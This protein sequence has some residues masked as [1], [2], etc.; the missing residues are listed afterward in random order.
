MLE[1]GHP[2][3]LKGGKRPYHTII[4]A[5]ALRGDELFLSYGV[6]G[7]YMQVGRFSQLADRTRLILV[8]V[9]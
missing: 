8:L 4:P 9:R 7:G 5:M 2:N 1:E 6:M 3:A